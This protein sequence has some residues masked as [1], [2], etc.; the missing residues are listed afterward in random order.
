[1]Y[2][3][4]SHGIT[5]VKYKLSFIVTCFGGKLISRNWNGHILRD[6]NFAICQKHTLT[7]TKFRENSQNTGLHQQT[8]SLGSGTTDF[9]LPK[10]YIP[11]TLNKTINQHETENSLTCSFTTKQSCTEC[12]TQSVCDYS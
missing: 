7:G 9:N 8:V 12:L 4:L 11:M 2:L 5:V 1:M 10:Q 6:L 3:C